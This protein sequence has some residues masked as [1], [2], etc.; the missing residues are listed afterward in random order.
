M[1]TTC[2][3]GSRGVAGPKLEFARSER[4]KEGRDKQSQLPSSVAP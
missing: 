4:P 2:G 3:K 1:L